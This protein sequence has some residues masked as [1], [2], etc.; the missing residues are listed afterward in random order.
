MAGSIMAIFL[1]TLADSLTWGWQNIQTKLADL[2]VPK[3]GSS[4]AISTVPNSVAFQRSK[5]IDVTN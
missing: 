1:A 3:E 5:G 4:V 2:L